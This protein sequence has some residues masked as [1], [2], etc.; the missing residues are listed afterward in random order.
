MFCTVITRDIVYWVLIHADD[1]VAIIDKSSRLGGNVH[2][3]GYL[4]L[5]YREKSKIY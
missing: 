1:D 5:Y 4:N 3:I 2:D